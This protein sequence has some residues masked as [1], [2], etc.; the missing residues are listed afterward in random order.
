MF[1]ETPSLQSI[2]DPQRASTLAVETCLICES[3]SLIACRFWYLHLL[4]ALGVEINPTHCPLNLVKTDIIKSFKTC[5]AYCPYSMIGDQEMF[6]PSHE[7]IL[8]LCQ[9]WDWKAFLRLLLKWTKR[10][11]FCP[12]LQIDLICR[13]PVLM[14]R[15]E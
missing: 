4:L 11:E 6:L 1:I 8:S 5:T 2:H 3:Y 9:A 12:M 13:S 14:L 15:K 7:Y 10:R